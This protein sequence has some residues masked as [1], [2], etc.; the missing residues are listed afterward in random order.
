[1]NQVILL[2]V[3]VASTWTQGTASISKH[4]N[5]TLNLPTIN[6]MVPLPELSL[7]TN[8]LL[9]DFDPSQASGAADSASQSADKVKIK[10]QDPGSNDEYSN[11]PIKQP[12]EIKPWRKPLGWSFVGVGGASILAGAGCLAGWLV[13]KGSATPDNDKINKLKIS[14]IVLGSVG[15]AILITGIA[16]LLWEE[17]APIKT[18]VAVGP[19]YTGMLVSGSF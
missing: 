7:K 19:G 12:N 11:L 3:M 5:L 9:A 2:V 1:M 18:E 4:H 13:E 6:D 15:G 16:L 10:K 14:T 17:Y 8:T